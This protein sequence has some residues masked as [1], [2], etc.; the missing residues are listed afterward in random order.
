MI[1][2]PS[3]EQR[4]MLALSFE[5]NEHGF[6]YYHYRWSRGV[7]VT[8]QERD[9]YLNIPVFGS[10][11]AWRR[12]LKGRQTFAPRAY[13]PVLWKLLPKMPLSI[14]FCS[15]ILGLAVLASSY[16]EPITALAIIY[17]ATGGA[18]LLFG[19]LIVIAR[20]RKRQS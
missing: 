9:D 5:P 14:L 16:K 4:D 13:G 1:F 3:P 11:R 10:R 2:T 7:Q 12:S 15:V 18:M 19:V 17:A 20:V 6:L 8:V